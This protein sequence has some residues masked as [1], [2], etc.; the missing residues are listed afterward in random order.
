[1]TIGFAPGTACSSPIQ[2]CTV[3]LFFVFIR[4]AVFL[5]HTLLFLP[6][7]LPRLCAFKVSHGP[8][9]VKDVDQRLTIA[10]HLEDQ[11][12]E[13]CNVLLQVGA[14]T[15]QELDV[16]NA[17]AEDATLAERLGC[18]DSVNEAFGCRSCRRGRECELG[19]SSP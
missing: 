10:D 14:L 17:L 7:V 11:R 5:I 18:R 12:L 13:Q 2:A 15:L 1:L 19:S 4:G 6:L 16:L 8:S 9:S 3:L